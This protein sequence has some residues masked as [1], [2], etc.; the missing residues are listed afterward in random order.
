MSYH[1]QFSCSIS[2]WFVFL[3][4]LFHDPPRQEPKRESH[5]RFAR[6]IALGSVGGS[7]DRQDKRTFAVT[8]SHRYTTRADT[9]KA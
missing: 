9:C 5:Q 3:C 6:L 7:H 4:S 1:H 8:M 2:E